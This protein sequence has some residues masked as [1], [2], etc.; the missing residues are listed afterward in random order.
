MRAPLD[1]SILPLHAM[2]RGCGKQS[3]L[4]ANNGR[5]TRIPQLVAIVHRWVA[6]LAICAGTALALTVPAYAQEPQGA[7]ASTPGTAPPVA[8][9]RPKIGV[10]LSGG[11]ARGLTHIGVL[12]V[13]EEL[14]VPIDYISATSMGAIVGGLYA[15]GIPVSDMEQYV[16]AIDWPAFFSDQ[17]PRRELSV[18]RK[19]EETTY[20][21]PLELGVRDFSFK[22]ATGALSGQNLEMLLHSLTWR[23]DDI[24]NF[25]NLPIPFRAVADES[26]QRQGSRVRD[27]PLVPR[28]AR[29]HVGSTD[30]RPA[31]PRGEDARRRRSREEPA[32]RHRQSDGRPKW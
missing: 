29:K 25:D 23:E 9:R 8:Q 4:Q 17:P 6:A 2:Y 20:T 18:R 13:L 28:D 5:S 7:A 11:G 21:V 19:Q 31:R 1:S 22:L 26:R 12:K 16:R 32:R 27:R 14:R 30:F 15:S 3:A 24:G 10:V